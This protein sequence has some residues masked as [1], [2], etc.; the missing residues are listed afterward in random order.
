MFLLIVVEAKI[1]K[2]N[3]NKIVKKSRKKK[4]LAKI[5][6]RYVCIKRRGRALREKIKN[7]LEKP[8]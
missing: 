1:R 7:N 6:P 2:K 5:P 8:I 4:S 3:N